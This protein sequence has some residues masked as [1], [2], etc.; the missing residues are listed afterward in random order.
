MTA[1]VP[2]A[3]PRARVRPRAGL[4]S[5]TSQDEPQGVRVILPP[6]PTIDKSNDSHA[7]T[8]PV[9][10]SKE[11]TPVAATV[12]QSVAGLGV[13]VMGT[14]PPAAHEHIRR[15]LLAPPLH[16]AASM[17]SAIYHLITWVWFRC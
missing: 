2:V 17:L 11:D 1:A 6:A 12:S 7:I 10:I 16:P 15:R 9:R 8:V 14:S 13:S 4:I 3:V 5:R